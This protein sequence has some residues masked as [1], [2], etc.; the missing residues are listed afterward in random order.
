MLYRFSILFVLLFTIENIIYGQVKYT[1]EY[2]DENVFLGDN[3]IPR[4]KP[5]SLLYFHFKGCPG[6]EKM[7]QTTF[8]DSAV[9]TFMKIH[10]HI[11]LILLNLF[12][13]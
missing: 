5:F 2:G 9:V 6:C 13:F 3:K 4:E 11:F 10:F 1:A 8:K 12:L 7:D